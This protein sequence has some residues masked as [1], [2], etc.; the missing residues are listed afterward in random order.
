MTKT[1]DGGLTYN[2]QAADLSTLTNQLISGDSVSAAT[3]SYTDKNAAS[4]TKVVTLDAVTLSDNNNGGNYT[5]TLAGN[6]TST[7]TRKN[8][9]AAYTASNK[10][11]DGT[12]AATVVGASSDIVTNDIV[13]FANTSATF[14]SKNVGTGK[15]VDISGINIG[16][17]DAGNYALQN[18]TASTTANVTKKD[19]SITGTATNVTYLSLIHI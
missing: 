12:T 10:V 16:G 11:Y 18:T 9:T 3:I 7:I 4:G 2:T 1:Y 6:S 8:L 17:T 5:V 15:A 19:A 14:D 13:T